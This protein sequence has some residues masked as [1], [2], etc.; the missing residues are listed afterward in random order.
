MNA[1]LAILN[2]KLTK[3]GLALALVGFGAATA[4]TVTDIRDVPRV[5]SRHDSI[6]VELLKTAKTTLCLNIADRRRTDWTL[7]LESK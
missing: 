6:T 4:K 3:I 5:L 7:C 2:H 1:L